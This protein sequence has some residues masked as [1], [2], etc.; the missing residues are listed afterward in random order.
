MCGIGGCVVP[1]GQTPDREALT[2]L[3]DAI[4]HRG[5]DD[6][7][8][9]IVD[10]VGLVHR[11]LSIVDPTPAGHQPMRHRSG[12]WWITYNGEV[13]NHLELRSELG[14]VPW[15]SGTDTE[16]L[17]EALSQWGEAAIDR[18]N[19][20]FAYAA[21]DLENRRLIVVRDRFGVKPLYYCKHEGAIW[22]ASEMK[23]LLAAGVPRRP[24]VDVLGHA[25]WNAWANGSATPI[26]G[27]QRLLPGS[28]M[29]IDL[30]TLEIEIKPWFDP[31]S[32]VDSDLA[33]ELEAADPET[34]ANRLLAA[35][36]ASVGRRLMAD[37]PV[38][39]MC[40]GGLDSSFLSALASESHP[41]IHAFNA[42]AIDQP[43]FDEGPYAELV[44]NHLGIELHTVR[45]NAESWRADLV[46]VTLQNEYPLLHPGAVPTSQIAALA[47]ANGIKV[48]LTGEGADEL[49]GGYLYLHR[50]E[51]SDFAA[52]HKPA[53]AAARL[54]YRRL[55]RVG[56]LPTKPQPERAFVDWLAAEHPPLGF[57]AAAPE[58]YEAD[59][60]RR[61]GA[62]YGHHRGSRRRLEGALL[63][64]LSTY[65]PHLLNQLDKNT[66]QASIEGRTPFLDPEVVKLCVNLPLET[67]LEPNTKS[68]LRDVGSRVLPREIIERPKQGFGF[69]V[70]H[71]LRP[72]TR[73][74]FI[75][76]GMLRE[77]LGVAKGTWGDIL[78]KL[79]DQG[80][81]LFWTGEI[82][83]RGVL[84]QHSQE[85]IEDD[86]WSAPDLLFSASPPQT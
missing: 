38:G 30:E 77:T 33:A 2:R 85:Q 78:A 8:T 34:R 45:T 47:R 51:R 75:A 25:L 69:P 37:V 7:G 27:V 83:C 48:L 63:T 62:A 5:P 84:E 19:G 54:L 65:L 26:E 11:R 72:A 14:D 40:S 10:T 64:E 73:P 60:A 12:R 28:Q 18:C 3:A 67:K 24:Q 46:P 1:P 36:R 22:F 20:L 58:R 29:T 81:M 9:E 21:I 52:R 53:E 42:R 82:W 13:F 55:Q 16:T 32:L 80:V 17:L 68:I 44:A 74:E 61:A 6:V 15:R 57:P 23:G 56:I 39:T 71:Y 43:G 31:V 49:L 59:V 4:T 79:P 35:L 86:L 41:S 66:M 70:E 50:S 76:D